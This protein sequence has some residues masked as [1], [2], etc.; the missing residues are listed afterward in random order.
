MNGSLTLQG[1]MDGGGNDKKGKGLDFQ[2][3]KD[4][5]RGE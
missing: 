2:S 5:Q 4:K 3:G 1:M